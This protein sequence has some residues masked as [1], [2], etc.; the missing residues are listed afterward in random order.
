MGHHSLLPSRFSKT[1]PLQTFLPFST[2]PLFAVI[3]FG[4]P[5][6]LPFIGDVDEY[7]TCYRYNYDVKSSVLNVTARPAE[8]HETPVQWLNATLVIAKYMQ[9]TQG[10]DNLRGWKVGYNSSFLV[11]DAQGRPKKVA[12]PDLYVVDDQHRLSIVLEVANTQTMENV[13]KKARDVWMRTPDIVGVIIIKLEEVN[14][15]SRNVKKKWRPTEPF[16]SFEEWMKIHRSGGEIKY[17]GVSWIG[18]YY[19]KFLIFIKTAPAVPNAPVYLIR[20]GC[21]WLYFLT[22]FLTGISR[23]IDPRNS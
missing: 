1:S 20:L 21:S 10:S 4:K 16:V 22:S 11:L 23:T 2:C 7:L 8:M 9:K 13:L 6:K 17:D 12:S 5:L 15:P 14:A 18:D 3:V 19:A